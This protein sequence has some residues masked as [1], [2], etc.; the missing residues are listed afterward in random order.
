MQ[1]R[2]RAGGACAWRV[3]AGLCLIAAA[4][5]WPTHGQEQGPPLGTVTG[6][7]IN[8]TTDQPVFQALVSVVGEGRS[9]ATAGDGRFTV[10]G[11]PVGVY[12]LEVRA[13]GYAPFVLSDVVIGSGKPYTVE[14]ALDPLPVDLDAVTVQATY[15]RR[16]TQSLSSTQRLET[17]E[18]RRAPG[19]FEDVVRAIAVLPGIG[20]P[21]EG[22]NDLVVRGGA[23]F[24]NL[25]LVDGIRVPNINHFGSQG[26]TGGPVSLI[27]ID[28]VRD[29]SFSSGGFGVRYGDRTASVTNISLREGGRSFSGEL[30]LSA[31][32][33][34]AIVE[35]PV[36]AGSFLLSARRS[37][38]DLIFQAAGQPFVPRYWDFTLK[39]TQDLGARDRLSFLSIGALDDVSFQNSTADDRFDNRR[40]LAPEMRQYFGGFTWTRFLARGSVR[41][42]L[43]RSYVRFASVQRDSLETVPPIFSNRSVEGETTL[44]TDLDV[45]VSPSVDLESG[46]IIRLADELT[47]DISIDGALRQDDSGQPSPLALDTS[48]TAFAGAA[49]VQ[50]GWRIGGALRL[51]MGVRGDYYG[52]IGAWRAAPRFAIR[53]GVDEATTI[54][55]STGRFYQ[56]PAYIWLIGNP[57]NSTALKPLFSDQIVAGFERLLRDDLKLQIEGFY[58][59][60]RDY[61]TRV[62]RPQ[63]VLAPSGFEDATNDIPYGLEPLT[64]Q[65][66]GTAYGAEFFLQKKLSRIP[67]FGLLSLT[68]SRSK[69]A[70][71]DEIPRPGA[72]DAR[73]IGTALAGYRPHSAW[74]VSGKFRFATGRPTTPFVGAGPQSG[75]LD[76]TKYNADR[77]PTFHALDLRVDR[78]W[79]FRG[80]QLEVYLDVQNV[81]A[82][83]NVTDR[84]WNPRTGQPAVNDGITVL[85]TIGLNFEF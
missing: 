81:Y 45:I 29:V 16:A 62:W 50:M 12:S 26:S 18:T 69:F 71:I 73:V 32:G 54:T 23:P 82:R 80:S 27:N 46:V 65:G 51:V 34:G 75:Q 30:N 22:R 56:A 60:Y 36:G 3:A 17:E 52:T 31:T 83:K 1:S 33:I 57:L 64:S 49:Y 38:L 59:R 21:V 40:I 14:I 37:Y 19:G 85:P 10:I 61:P 72:Y 84:Y 39:V 25:F 66:E 7:V 74:G 58:K 43:G 76:F 79:N 55:A 6:R 5:P 63:A 11:I 24:E 68:V 20:V 35:G 41:G 78:R 13:I 8:A 2:G 44:R 15:F 4:F 9:A 42:T 53:L 28:F 48:F 47:Y 70:G 77:F 67:I